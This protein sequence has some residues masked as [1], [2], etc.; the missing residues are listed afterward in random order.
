MSTE[1]GTEPV[2]VIR[3]DGVDEAHMPKGRIVYPHPAPGLATKETLIRAVKK[4]KGPLKS[5]R[6]P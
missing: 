3:R 6:I 4:L 5:K 1:K 2:V